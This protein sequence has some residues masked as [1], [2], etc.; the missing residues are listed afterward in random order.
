MDDGIYT[1]YSWYRSGIQNGPD[2]FSLS[3][4]GSLCELLSYEGSFM[5][6]DGPANGQIS[7]DI[8]L[9]ENSSALGESLQ[10]FGGTWTGPS[11]DTPG[12]T[13]I[14]PCPNDWNLSG[15]VNN[16]QD[17]ETP[18]TITS[19]QVIAST[20]IVDYDSALEIILNPNFETKLGA[21][22]EAFI[23]GCNNGGG[24]SNNNP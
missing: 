2:G 5:A 3:I 4:P 13:N 12:S 22:F 19:S 24:G 9:N 6:T 1:Y 20:A 11:D 15:T 23:D 8:G 7:T 14:L 10:L 17:Y 18:G 21:T 16:N